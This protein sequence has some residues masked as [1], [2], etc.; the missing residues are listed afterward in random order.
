MNLSHDQ[1]CTELIELNL[2]TCTQCKLRNRK[3]PRSWENFLFNY[4]SRFGEKGHGETEEGICC[5]WK[6]L[7]VLKCQNDFETDYRII[8]TRTERGNKFLFLW[9]LSDADDDCFGTFF[10]NCCCTILKFV[11]KLVKIS[12]SHGFIGYCTV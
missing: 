9:L 4:W 8:V 2:I 3:L 1:L 7:R 6:W 10:Y 5:L 11:F 12:C